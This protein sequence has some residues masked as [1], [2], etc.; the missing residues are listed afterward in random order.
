M[1]DSL[2]FNHKLSGFPPIPWRYAVKL[3]YQAVVEGIL[4]SWTFSAAFHIRREFIHRLSTKNDRV[5][6]RKTDA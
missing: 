1:G 4:L 3:T 2:E 5:I 6:H